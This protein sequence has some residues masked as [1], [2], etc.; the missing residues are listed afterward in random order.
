M[1]ES[2]TALARRASETLAPRGKSPL[3]AGADALTSIGV[4]GALIGSSLAGGSLFWVRASLGQNQLAMHQT[5]RDG[6]ISIG[7]VSEQLYGEGFLAAWHEVLEEELGEAR[8]REILYRVG[9]RGARWEVRRAIDR[10]VW[11]PGLLRALVG[12]P[13][14]LDKVRSS[15]LY[16]ALV[17]ETLGILFRMIMTEGGWG[18]VAELDLRGEPIRVVVENTPEPRRTG[19]TGRCSCYLM[20]G[21]YTGYFETLFGTAFSGRETTC[22]ARGDRF[23]TFELTRDGAR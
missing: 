11:V 12:R 2:V 10:K 1:L 14:M 19:A 9:V 5:T 15:K 3:A 17:R 4:R 7:H 18:R 16:H 8:T 6:E 20:T 21:I 13:E 22:A 23:C